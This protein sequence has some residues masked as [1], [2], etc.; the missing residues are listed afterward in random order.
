MADASSQPSEKGNG[1]SLIPVEA[2][3]SRV[4]NTERGTQACALPLHQYRPTE[5]SQVSTDD[6]FAAF[7]FVR[8]QNTCVPL[9]RT[10]IVYQNFCGLDC[11]RYDKA[12]IA[13]TGTRC[14]TR[15]AKT[16]IPHRLQIRCGIF[17]H[18]LTTMRNVQWNYL[19]P[20]SS[21][22]IS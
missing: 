2:L 15:C 11:R 10:R 8:S 14:R 17:L 4:G 13:Q 20:R 21:Q 7:L 6:C 5:I 22:S 18:C 19:K 3:R 12:Q 9:N 16:Q 1:L